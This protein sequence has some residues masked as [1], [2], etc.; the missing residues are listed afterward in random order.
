[1]FD[2]FL[3]HRV[4][5]QHSTPKREETKQQSSKQ[6]PLL[7]INEMPDCRSVF[8]HFRC[9]ILRPHPVLLQCVGNLRGRSVVSCPPPEAIRLVLTAFQIPKFDLMGRLRESIRELFPL[10]TCKQAGLLSGREIAKSTAAQHL[11]FHG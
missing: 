9:R 8:L 10:K 4:G 6:Q 7:P 1:M 3:S 5:P 2:F 11:P